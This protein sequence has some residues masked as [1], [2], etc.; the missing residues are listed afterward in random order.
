MEVD[1]DVAIIGGGMVGASLAVALARACPD[2]RI[3]VLEAVDMPDTGAEMGYQPSYDVRSTALSY[4]TR[5]IYE[6]LGLWDLLR[7]HLTPIKRI[8]VSDRGQFGVTRLRA[9]D[10]RLDALGYVTPNQWMGRVLWTGLRQYSNIQFRC[11]VQV[12][13]V[14]HQEQGV[15]LELASNE[16]GGS[17]ASTL[18]AQL[19]VLADG[20]RSGLRQQLGIQTEKRAYGQVALITTVSS[21]KHHDFVAYERFTDQGPMALLPLGG[22]DVEDHRSALIWTLPEH[23]ADAVL[24]ASDA[25]F[26]ELLGERFGHR[27]GG[28]VQV[29]SRHVY[30]LA[31]ERA[32]EQIRPGL[33]LVGNAAHSLHP[34]A[35]QG[36]NLAVREVMGLAELLAKAA[37]AGQGLGELSL[38]A[39][40]EEA[41]QEDQMRTIQASD[42]LVR[43]FSNA[44][45]PLVQARGVGLVTLDL[46]APLKQTFARYA[47]GLGGREA[48]LA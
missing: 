48:V 23:R 30:P 12:L 4:G 36:Y 2:L 26:L 3:T 28:F 43:L 19:A 33:V 46:V 37:R 14:Q 45:F 16:A 13:R 35:G 1:V 24:N 20:G 15:L 47:M 39:R 41:Q 29:G 18:R 11:P 8:H 44:K 40:Y 38:L 42:S 17:G 31:L 7:K 25:Q 32:L 5:L 9:E 10:Y 22:E 6:Q 21:R 34:V 27:L